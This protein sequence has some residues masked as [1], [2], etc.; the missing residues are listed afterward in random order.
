M[1]TLFRDSLEVVQDA[2]VALRLLQRNHTD[3]DLVLIDGK[4]LPRSET[5]QFA[6]SVRENISPVFPGM[7]VV[8]FS[9][10]LELIK[11]G[12]DACMDEDTIFDLIVFDSNGSMKQLA[13]VIN[14]MADLLKN[15]DSNLH[16]HSTRVKT[17]T[18]ILVALC[19]EE[20]ILPLSKAYHTTIASYFHD[21]GKLL[22]CES[23]LNKPSK[24][25][26]EEFSVMKTHTSLGVKVLENLSKIFA[27][28]NFVN[29]LFNV[30]K[31][32]HERFDA[33]GYPEGL[34]AE[35]IPLEARIV[36]IADVLEALTTDRPY[37]NAYSFEEA[38]NIM[39]EEQEH[40]DPKL[41]QLFIENAELFRD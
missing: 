30:M 11:A 24:L 33:R 23:I 25:S 31:Y 2:E 17:F 27:Q 5:I 40:F 29:V 28:N 41:L 7:V 15:K 9:F 34:R 37:R 38:L 26:E 12:I 10:D 21:F 19:V 36:A 8:Q 32:H 6:R 4:T 18:Q 14:F 20:G 1:F 35:Q 39:T 13:L 22:I 3:Y 16:R